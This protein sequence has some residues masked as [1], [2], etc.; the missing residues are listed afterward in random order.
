MI[1][2]ITVLSS[3]GKTIGVTY[4]KRAQGLVKKGRARYLDG[5][6][7]V[8][9][10][11]RSPIDEFT[12]QEDDMN[13][14]FNFDEFIEKTKAA[15][16]VAGEGINYAADKAEVAVEKAIAALKKSFEDI[17]VKAEQMNEESAKSED[18]LEALE[19]E[20][21]EAIEELIESDEAATI[22]EMISEIGDED[23]EE[24]IRA[25]IRSKIERE[26][27]V[28]ERE[29]Q[30]R[31]KISEYQ[32][33]ASELSKSAAVTISDAANK[34]KEA[35]AAAKESLKQKEAELKA[36]LSENKSAE[37][38]LTPEGIVRKMEEIRNENASLNDALL[39]IQNMPVG[40]PGDIA[41]QAK[42]EAIAG[43]VKSRE[44]TNREMLEMY[45][46]ILSMNLN[47]AAEQK[48][49][50]AAE[51]LNAREARRIAKAEE[52]EANSRM[53]ET[54]TN[55]IRA[56]A[57][58]DSNDDPNKF[59]ALCSVASKLSEKVEMT[60]ELYSYVIECIGNT[61][62]NEEPAKGEFFTNLI[63]K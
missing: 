22:E 62:F 12:S 18:D 7:T 6:E 63:N 37:V 39:S 56:V 36:K 4:P 16:H 61:D 3:E 42:A 13:N 52:E 17:F 21:E 14:N 32:K 30:Y 19:A 20:V 35:I 44:Q 11:A 1:K 38:D 41:T 47:Y 2:N 23:L 45:K 49:V 53:V 51:D 5:D 29:K 10:L 57:E 9:L 24:R 31:E 54:L 34:T 33:R 26:K 60:P 46:G 50:R 58:L 55:L 40:G 43:M 48:A 27:A 28:R 59:E 15:A 8:I 25:K